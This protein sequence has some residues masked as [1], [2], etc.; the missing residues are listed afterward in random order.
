MSGT[1]LRDSLRDGLRD[2]LRD[3]FPELFPGKFPGRF[4]GR[5]PGQFFISVLGLGGLAGHRRLGS[6]AAGRCGRG[7]AAGARE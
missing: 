7:W 3:R 5:F 2:G 6:W 4:S 1:D